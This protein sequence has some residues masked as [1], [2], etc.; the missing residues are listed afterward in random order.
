[1][2]Q[3]ADTGMRKIKGHTVCLGIAAQP[4]SPLPEALP[5]T[6]QP[7]EGGANPA[8]LGTARLWDLGG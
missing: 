3:L 7:P 2:R 4:G 1:M 5:A 8:V 6:D